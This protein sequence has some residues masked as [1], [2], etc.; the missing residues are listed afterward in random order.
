MSL[1][2]IFLISMLCF[3]ATNVVS[4]NELKEFLKEHIHELKSIEYAKNLFGQRPYN[5][6]DDPTVSNIY[7]QYIINSDVYIKTCCWQ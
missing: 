3:V 1:L 7:I 6:N 4:K 2:S 5:G